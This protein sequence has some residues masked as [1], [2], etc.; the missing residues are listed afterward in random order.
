MF[1]TPFGKLKLDSPQLYRCPCEAQGPK[2]V[3]PLAELLPKRTSPELAYL[4]TK[5]AALASYGLSLRLLE[6][7]RRRRQLIDTHASPLHHRRRRDA[8]RRLGR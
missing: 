2:S 3:S 1:R 4:E 8:L 5:F 7:E 6:E